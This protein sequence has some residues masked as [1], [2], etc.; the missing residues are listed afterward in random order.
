MTQGTRHLPADERRAGIV[1]ATVSLAAEQNP[2]AITT[3]AI[4]KHLNLTQGALFRHFASKDAIWQAVVEWVTERL[5]GRVEQ[6]IADAG[7]PLA[8]LEAAFFTHIEFVATY[9]GVPRLLFSELQ[10]PD[11]SPAKRV[12][13]TLLRR[14]GER[15]TASIEAG[16]ACGEIAQEVDPAAAATLF[17]GTIQGL[18]MQSLLAGDVGRLR[19]DAPGAFAIYRRGIR[20]TP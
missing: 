8:G 17:I 11:D 14:Y 2:S 4:A 9:P 5:L 13:R 18:V 15:L 6:A 20:S 10:R 12:V 3:A 16:R 7:S 1:E 19:A